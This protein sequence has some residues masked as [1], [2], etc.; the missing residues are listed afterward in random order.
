MTRPL[1]IALLVATSLFAQ[2][3][4][5]V[6]DLAAGKFL[7]AKRDLTDP[8]FAETVVLLIRY[9]EKGAMGLI[10]NRPTKVPLSK[11][12]A[13][14]PAAKGRKDPVYLGGPVGLEGALGLLR[15]S[16]QPEG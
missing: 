6:R 13:D 14:I 7:I 12:F 2:R 8:N 16:K 11:V 15:A 9:D 3:G 5:I 10:V 4:G 1:V